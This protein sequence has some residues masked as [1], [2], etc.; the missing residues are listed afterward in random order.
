ME[1]RDGHSNSAIAMTKSLLEDWDTKDRLA[2]EPKSTRS[3]NKFTN[4]V[5]NRDTSISIHEITKWKI[6]EYILVT[7]LGAAL[8]SFAV[9][10]KTRPLAFGAST[11]PWRPYVIRIFDGAYAC[12]V[13]ATSKG[14]WAFK[15][16]T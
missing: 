13:L 2:P 3:S 11:L 15:L 12:T 16:P 1:T 14:H 10:K 4:K 8:A 5:S 6:N 7:M 9:S